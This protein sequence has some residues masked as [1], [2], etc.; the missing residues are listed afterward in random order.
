[1]DQININFDA[2]DFGN[3][4]NAHKMILQL[5]WNFMKMKDPK[6][7]ANIKDICMNT[8]EEVEKKYPKNLFS[9]EIENVFA[10]ID[11]NGKPFLS[12]IQGGKIDK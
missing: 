8:A 2:T 7:A 12:I 9:N 10:D 1:M 6:T 11:D 5:L 4:V 3:R